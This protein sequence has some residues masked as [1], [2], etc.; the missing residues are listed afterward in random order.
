MLTAGLSLGE[1]LSTES[2]KNGHA[3]LS[4]KLL[5]HLRKRKSQSSS[6]P[7][8]FVAYFNL[9]YTSRTMKS[10]LHVPLASFFLSTLK[11]KYISI[12]NCPY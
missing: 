4:K 12:E 6:F 7:T 3:C 8:L 11:C 1:E 9:S 10:N 5:K 2:G